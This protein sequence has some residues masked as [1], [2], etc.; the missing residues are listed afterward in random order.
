MRAL[1]SLALATQTDRF[2]PSV[3][4][5]QLAE[6]KQL[7]VDGVDKMTKSEKLKKLWSKWNFAHLNFLKGLM[8]WISG[9]GQEAQEILTKVPKSQ[10]GRYALNLWNFL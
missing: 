6:L 2:K 3:E 7:L 4:N 1:V 9:E 5:F 10:V 8:L